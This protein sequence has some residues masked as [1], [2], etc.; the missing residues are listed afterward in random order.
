MS[1]KWD[2]EADVVV[3]G[4]GLAGAVAALEAHDAGA[5]VIILEKSQYPGGCSILG[6]GIVECADDVAAAT[7]YPGNGRR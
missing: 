1:T 6:A 3:V 7:E 2:K 5:E 4:Y